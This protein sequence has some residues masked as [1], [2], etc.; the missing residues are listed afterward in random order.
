LTQALGRGRGR[1]SHS[2]ISIQKEK[3]ADPGSR[4]TDEIVIIRKRACDCDGEPILIRGS[5]VD[6]FL[7]VCSLSGMH[8]TKSVMY[9]M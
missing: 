9:D 2:E 7:N 8:I 5:Y 4:K 1:Q 3:R 6:V